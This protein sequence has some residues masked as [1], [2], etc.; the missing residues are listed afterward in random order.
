MAGLK[1][2][3]IYKVY[4]NGV[5]AVND[6]CMEIE[7]KEFIVF[8]GPSGCG[9]STTLRMIAGLED[10]SAGELFIGDTIVN[11]L[12]PV[13]RDIAMVFQNYAL[14]PHMTVYNNMAFGLKMAKIPKEE[15][16]RSKIKAL[17]KSGKP[18][19][20]IQLLFARVP[21][22]KLDDNGNLVYENGNPVYEYKTDK[23]GNVIKDK[24]GNP[25][26]LKRPYTDEERLG[27]VIRD[28]SGNPVLI[29]KNQT[30]NGK[31]V[32]KMRKY[33]KEEIRKKIYSAA[34]ILAITEYLDRKPKAM[35]GGQRQRVAL[36]RALVREP[37]VF[38]LDEPLSNLDAKLRTAMRAEISKLHKSLQ[39]TFIYV[40]HDQVEAMTMGTRIVVMKD[41]CVQQIDTPKNLY[42]Y[43]GNKFVAGF[44]GTPQM[45]FFEGKLLSDKEK[46]TV[47]LD[48]APVSWEIPAFYLVKADYNYL[49]GDRPV[50]IGIRPENVSIDADLY[51]FKVKCKI[52]HIEELGT[53][54]QIFAD[55]NLENDGN[56]AESATRIII[57]APADC[58]YE[59]GDIIEISLDMSSIH[60]FDSQTENTIAPRIPTAVKVDAT[61]KANNL[62]IEGNSLPLPP[63]MELGDGEYSVIIP[64]SAV[65]LGGDI[66]AEAIKTENVNGQRLVHIKLGDR[67]L[68]ALAGEDEKIT[69][70]VNIGFDLKQLSVIKNGETVVEPLSTL[71]TVNGQYIKTKRGTVGGAKPATETI[72]CYAIGNS[73]IDCPE[74]KVNRLSDICGNMI[75]NKQLK[76]EFG[77]YGI[78]INLSTLENGVTATIKAIKNYGTEKFLIC[79]ADGQNINVAL[80]G[81]DADAYM[82][83]E[84]TQIKLLIDPE[85]ISVVDME[86][87]I[88]LV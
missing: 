73:T 52:S 87:G 22:E 31:T 13:D 37:K 16:D 47:T 21:K 41:G 58:Q 67:T 50:T 61:V 39:T 45:N 70:S 7:D 43:P 18:M 53:D 75:Y 28:D 27:P 42:R 84:G 5:K 1:L 66:K 80:N 65:K 60:L 20:F 57:K 68:F 44:I 4:P 12:E 88:R 78:N 74:H 77:A 3:H 38:L 55:L 14:Y 56:V 69:K 36:G 33:T 46:I 79:D 48:N 40:T 25:V 9:K 23:K 6:F 17:T 71:N 51:P 29:I 62:I 54:C 8:V 85:T 81:D 49:S 59:Y 34:K 32:Y 86:S 82:G 24:N 35:S 64:T 10:I 83:K 2:N 76:F 15:R 30:K 72:N 26:I 19:N 11:N 63:A